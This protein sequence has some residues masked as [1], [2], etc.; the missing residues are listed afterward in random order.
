MAKLNQ[1][2]ILIISVL[3]HFGPKVN[4]RFHIHEMC[5]KCVNYDR[6]RTEIQT[7]TMRRHLKF[8]IL[9]TSENEAKNISMF[10][11]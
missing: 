3:T 10:Q 6:T 8:E 9:F 4:T 1:F 2:V 11:T 5:K 7:Q